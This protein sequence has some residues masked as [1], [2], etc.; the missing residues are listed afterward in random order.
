MMTV[1][2][3]KKTNIFFRDVEVE[4]AKNDVLEIGYLVEN[5]KM[6]LDFKLNQ[7]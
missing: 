3:S 4:V 6:R 5:N 2:F 1:F 7:E